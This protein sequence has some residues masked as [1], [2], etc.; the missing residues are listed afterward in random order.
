M[1]DR[2]RPVSSNT[3][4]REVLRLT[5]LG[6]VVIGV[7]ILVGCFLLLWNESGQAHLETPSPTT[8][9]KP[10]RIPAPGESIEHSRD[11]DPFRPPPSVEKGPVSVPA[12]TGPKRWDLQRLPAGWNPELAAR[13]ASWFE[14][15]D[16]SDHDSE[17]L[18]KIEDV[19]DA[20]EAFLK[21]LGPEAL[22]TLGAILKAEP[23]FLNRRFMLRALGDLGP[24]SEDT[25]FVLHEFY[26]D[27]RSQLGS[28]SETNH[29]IEAMG[30][31][32]NETA[33]TDLQSFIETP[34]TSAYDRDKFV[35]AL[36]DHPRSVEALPQFLHLGHEDQDVGTR[37]HA[38]QAVGKMGPKGAEAIGDLISAWEREPMYHVRQTILG[39][40]GKIGDARALPFLERV[41]RTA[42]PSSDRLSAARAIF[43]IGTPQALKILRALIPDERDENVRAS[44]QGWI[45][46]GK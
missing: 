38:W 43:R 3:M 20:L 33:F 46:K 22:P 10:A 1:T 21:T 23:D 4:R 45:E 26:L 37:N 17:K 18:K 25:T 31:L 8:I 14:A 12:G 19:R 9:P 41:A 34:E 40:I 44:Y 30:R 36:G 27:R 7:A 35:Q 28:R 42:T 24:K 32:R 29:V 16:V 11:G 13:I 39:T 15:M 5:V 2:K 6:P